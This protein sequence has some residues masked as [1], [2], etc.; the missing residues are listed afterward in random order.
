MS[1]TRIVEQQLIATFL[2]APD[3]IIRD[4]DDLFICEDSR[5]IY[6][7]MM[8][9]IDDGAQVDAAKVVF[10]MGDQDKEAYAKVLEFREYA[11][12]TMKKFFPEDIRWCVNKLREAKIRRELAHEAENPAIDYDAI[13]EKVNSIEVSAAAKD[14]AKTE[15][16]L[17][18]LFDDLSIPES[19][20]MYCGFTAIDKATRGWRRG[21][22][23]SIMARTTVGKT[24]LMLNMA[25]RLARGGFRITFFSM[26]GALAGIM[27]RMVQINRGVG[28]LSV[29]P[30]YIRD[31][32]MRDAKFAEDY[33][34]IF[35]HNQIYSV[36]DMGPII[37]K[38][39]PDVVF[40]D[41]LNLV[42]SKSDGSPYERTTQT[43]TD[44]K[45]MA[46]EKN[47]CLIYANQISRLGED[48]SI[49]VKL[50]HARD[51]GA[52]EELSDF[53]IG[54][55]RPGM[56]KTD[57]S[58][59]SRIKMELLKCKRGYTTGLEAILKDSGRIE[60]AL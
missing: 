37:D 13:R 21:D 2:A 11:A 47:V 16:G 17:R 25:D 38:E 20:K 56:N 9:A 3:L 7:A 42:K 53:I 52:C 46:I 30:E 43:V 28:F 58:E 39:R 57:L 51:S 41:F 8:N 29:T 33:K 18:E 35:W 26:E 55:W 32:M 5:S 36:A 22:L 15:Q 12:H 54:A 49:P 59:K 44:M 6:R 1:E 45:A 31:V 4:I 10:F 48:G 60:E 27:E 34:D 19:K 24:W 40:I 23:V 14:G 50:H